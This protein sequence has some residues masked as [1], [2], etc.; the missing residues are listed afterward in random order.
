QTISGTFQVSGGGST[1]I[2][3]PPPPSGNNC[4]ALQQQVNS[5]QQQLTAISQQIQAREQYD[6]AHG[7]SVLSDPTIQRL[8]AQFQTVDAQ[9]TAAV[10]ALNACQLG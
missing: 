4:T 3:P 10:N 5:L 6:N 9:Y 1:I 7:I 8:S 2:P